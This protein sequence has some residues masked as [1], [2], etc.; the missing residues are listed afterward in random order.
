MLGL[1]LEVRSSLRRASSSLT[2]LQNGPI[3]FADFSDDESA[4]ANQFSWHQLADIFYIDQPVGQ[5]RLSV[6]LLH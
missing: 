3:R 1:L 2:L 4:H 5:C 6:S